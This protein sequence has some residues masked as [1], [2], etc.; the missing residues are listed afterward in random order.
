MSLYTSGQIFVLFLHSSRKYLKFWKKAGLILIA[1]NA[2]A[3]KIR[4]SI[5]QEVAKIIDDISFL[6]S[7]VLQLL[8]MV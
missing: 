2:S 4:G 8:Y 6:I 3:S 1:Y 5:L 7:E